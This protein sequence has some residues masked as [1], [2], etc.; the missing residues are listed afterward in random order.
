MKIRYR[1]EQMDCPTEEAMIRKS[2]AQLPEVEAL[3]F[4]LIERVLE[5]EHRLDDAAPIARAIAALG[6]TPVPLPETPQATAATTFEG[7]RLALR[8]VVTSGIAGVAAIGAE[9]V[10][11]I[12]GEETSPLVLACALVAILAGGLDT[13][14]KGLVS[15]RTL[16]LNINFLMSVAVLGAML[17]GKWPEAAM[18]VWLFGVAELIERLSAERA[19]HAI[20]AVLA[21]APDH[22][23][24]QLPDG[25]WREM[26]VAS[27]EPGARVRTR[28]GERVALDGVVIS[29]RSA[30]NEA[31][32]TGEAMPVDKDVG[33]PVYAGS[34]NQGGSFEFRVT[35]AK[36]A[37]TLDRIARAVQA[38]QAQKAPTQ[39][40]VDRFAQHYTPAV[41]V[42]AGLVALAPP[43]LLGAAWPTWI[44]RGLVLL[45]IACPCALVISTPVTIASGLA[46]AARR[47]LVAKGGL[48]L[49]RARQLRAI[50]FDKTGTLTHGE[51]ALTDVLSLDAA[52]REPEALRIAA[53]LDALSEH[54]VAAAIVAG[55]D[56]A[57]AR[58]S[59]FAA[60]PGRGVTGVVEGR[61]YFLGN[62]R[63]AEE[64][65]VC[66]PAI[67]ATLERL[68]LEAKT[69][70]VLATET[71]ALA[72]FAV[73]DTVRDGA[74][75]AVAALIA[76]G[77]RPVMLSG[78]NARTVRAIAAQVGI[79]DARGELLPEDKLA[80]IATLSAAGGV[81]MVGDGI[82]DAPALARADLGFA[83]ATHGTDAAIETADV[84]LMT[85][86][87][88][89][90]PAFVQLSRRTGRILWQ[91]I[92]FALG[93]K[94]CFVVLAVA[95][96]STLWQAVFA[97]LGASLIVVTN[98]LRLLRDGRTRTEAEQ[99]S[100]G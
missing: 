3:R 42:V 13:L 34:I 68:E 28:P 36:G 64:R 2:L 26:P 27:L 86:D 49:E 35:A 93:L 95:G 39:R 22:A 58:V 85:N 21:L 79:E 51:P 6:F 67:E 69:V 15:L 70:V 88:R 77:I 8:D 66:S 38:A 10:A 18:V 20:R 45:V 83:M 90:I 46:A 29:G 1:I 60:L 91:N 62:H 75:Q 5:I 30:V 9:A 31:P 72:I 71:Q 89:R 82:N 76:L 78:D 96:H 81:A 80:L 99:A 12:S 54:P 74:R 32:I 25:T 59:E 100:M 56:G 40:F 98:G 11:W 63:L 65:G 87:L 7:P 84:A 50:A 61:R 44:Y 57:L 48:H 53:S 92:A 23:T 97:D 73:A 94:A 52:C 43:L 24:V 17:I 55:H 47:G 16:S 14:R 33:A 37:S 41:L 4:N 19:R